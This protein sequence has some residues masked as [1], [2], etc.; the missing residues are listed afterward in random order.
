MEN[1]G[2]E[3]AQAD[4]EMRQMLEEALNAAAAGQATD[5]QLRLL[6]WQAGLTDWK[7]NAHARTKSVG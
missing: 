2:W 7:P 4:L 1:M 3:A 6:A 5:E